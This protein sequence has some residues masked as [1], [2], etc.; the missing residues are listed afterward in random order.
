MEIPKQ[1][2]VIIIMA[3]M[4]SGKGMLINYIKETFLDVHVTVSCTTREKRPGEVEGREYHFIS[5]AEFDEK[6]KNEDF[7]EWAH[8]GLNRYG[9]LKSEILPYLESGKTVV[10]EIELQ[11]VEQLHQLLEGEQ[12][13]TVYIEA[14]GWEFLKERALARAPI[15]EEELHKR[16]ERYLK[17]VEAK[18]IADII[19]DNSSSDTALAKAAMKELIE[20]IKNK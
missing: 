17:E 4:G 10:A 20:T 19:I 8:F 7:L 12:M 14:G 5:E 1:G 15:T 16:H 2:H 6:V 11:G 9:T 18:K 3:P 13:V